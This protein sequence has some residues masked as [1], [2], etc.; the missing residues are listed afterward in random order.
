M[1]F[2]TSDVLSSDSLNSW[3]VLTIRLSKVSSLALVLFL[4]KPL[5]RLGFLIYTLALCVTESYAKRK[6]P[7]LL[8]GV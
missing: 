2:F 5:A 7:I 1:P 8:G 6:T 3:L 4:H